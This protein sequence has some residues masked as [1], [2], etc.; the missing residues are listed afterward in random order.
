M[1]I[2]LLGMILNDWCLLTPPHHQILF[3]DILNILPF[4]VGQSG[5]GGAL[6]PTP[7]C[8]SDE[9]DKS[10]GEGARE[11]GVLETSREG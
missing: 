7:S 2:Y 9:G 4:E 3:F 1:F 8:L 6:I 10:S 11:V 5:P